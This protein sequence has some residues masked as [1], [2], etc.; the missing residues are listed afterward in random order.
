MQIRVG[1]KGLRI[2]KLDKDESAIITGDEPNVEY[3]EIKYLENVQNIDLTAK[4]Q[5][6]DVDSDDSTDVLTKCTGYDGKVQRTMFSPADQA[7]LLGEHLT[8]DGFYASTG[9]DV[10]DE[11]ATGFMTPLNNGKI[12][13]VWLLRTKYSASDLSAESGGEGKLNPQSDTMSFRS[14]TRRADNAW[15]FYKVCNTEKEAD[16]FLKVETLNKIYKE[17]E[18]TPTVTPSGDQ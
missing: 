13:A 18:T 12:F 14:S 16:E 9:N 3:G 5:S 10:P 1:L 4:T 7:L 6:V 8:K 15:R 11:F 17:D 2:A